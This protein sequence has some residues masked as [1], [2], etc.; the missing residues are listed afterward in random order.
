MAGHI[1]RTFRKS[2]GRAIGYETDYDDHFNT[3]HKGN[4]LLRDTESPALHTLIKAGVHSY[5]KA[6]GQPMADDTELADF[7]QVDDVNRIPLPANAPYLTKTGVVFCY[8]QYEIAPYAAGIITFE[9]P[10][11]KISSFLTDETK[12]LIPMLGEL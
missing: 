2:D 7:L 4:N 3:V 6:C 9:I 8:T 12:A 5:F 1:G 11:T 10:F